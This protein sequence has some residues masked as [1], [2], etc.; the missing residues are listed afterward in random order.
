[1]RIAIIRKTIPKFKAGDDFKP[2]NKSLPGYFDFF[3]NGEGNMTTS[4]EDF[5]FVLQVICN[6]ISG[7]EYTH[8]Q[9]DLEGKFYP[10][11]QDKPCP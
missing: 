8:S 10:E 6:K 1:V 11:Q 4:K 5:A 9:F 3:E 7:L 2:L